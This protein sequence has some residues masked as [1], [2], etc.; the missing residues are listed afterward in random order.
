MP[1][2]AY[3]LKELIKKHNDPNSD[4][5]IVSIMGT[6]SANFFPARINKDDKIRINDGEI[7][8]EEY[9]EEFDQPIVSKTGIENIDLVN[10]VVFSKSK[11]EIKKLIN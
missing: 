4:T 6:S 5:M 1:V 9:V 2:N 11:K 10:Y 7:I 3:K 8:W